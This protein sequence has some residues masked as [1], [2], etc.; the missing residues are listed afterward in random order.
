MIAVQELQARI[1]KLEAVAFEWHGR[2]I[3]ECPS[4]LSQQQREA[5]REAVVATGV[6][7]ALVLDGGM[8]VA[9]PCDDQI[10]ALQ[11]SVSRV[12]AKLDALIEA[13]GAEDQGEQEQSLSLD[14]DAIGGERDGSQ[15]LD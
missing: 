2:L 13:L 7:G 10:V 9:R 11:D 14:G 6:Q 15:G 3:I 5:L 1:E 12:E 8:K 4:Q